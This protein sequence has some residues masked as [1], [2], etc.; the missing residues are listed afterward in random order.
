MLRFSA[1]RARLTPN[2]WIVIAVTVI[3]IIAFILIEFGILP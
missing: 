1:S 3:L 2:T